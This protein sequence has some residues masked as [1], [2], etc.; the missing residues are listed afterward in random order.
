MKNILWL[1]FI[2][3]LFLNSQTYQEEWKKIET[4]KKQNLPKSALNEVNIIYNKALNEGNDIELLRAIIEKIKYIKQLEEQGD[5]KAILF[6]E[7]ELKKPHQNSTKLILKSILAQMYSRYYSYIYEDYTSKESNI[8]DIDTWSRERLQKKA[9]SLYWE[10]LGEESKYISLD[11]Y[12][13]ILIGGK[14]IKWLQPTLYD[15]L[16]SRALQNFNGDYSFSDSSLFGD[17]STFLLY[18]IYN[19]DK[20]SDKYKSLFIYKSLLK[21]HKENGDANALKSINL[22]RL[23]FINNHFDNKDSDYYIKALKRIKNNNKKAL[24][25]LALIYENRNNYIEALKYAK[26]G[27]ASGDKYVV[28]ISQNIINRITKKIAHIEIEY[29]NLPDENILSKVSYRNMDKLYIK[30]IKLSPKEEDEFLYKNWKEK[31]SYIS[32]LKSIKTFKVDLPKTYDYKR[33]ITEVSLGK[34]NIGSY[35]FVI[36]KDNNFSDSMSYQKINISKIAYVYNGSKI[37]VIDRL[38]GKPLEGVTVKFYKHEYIKSTNK[39]IFLA[40]KETDKNGFVSAKEFKTSFNLELINGEDRVI[41]DNSFYSSHGKKHWEKKSIIFFTDRAIY[42]PSQKI[43]FKG[44]AI[45]KSNYKA[46]KIL[47]NQEVTVSLFNTNNQKVET[48]KFKTDEFGSFYGWFT[49]P[50]SGR[51]GRMHISS[52]K[53]NGSKSF[54]VEEY[55]RA[56]FEVNFEPIKGE[57]SIGDKVTITGEAKAFSGQGVSNA[58]VS[59]KIERV[60]DFPWLSWEDKIPNFYPSIISSGNIKSDKNGKFI[61]KFDTT[62]KDS[63]WLEKYKPVITYKVSVNVTNS[64]GET[65]SESKNI[66]IG[67]VSIDAQMIVDNEIDINSKVNIKL[68]TTNLNGVFQ[69][70]KGRVVVEMIDL[71]KKHFRKRYWT[72]K[73]IDK[74]LYSKQ[75]FE[76]LFKNYRYYTDIKKEKIFIKTLYFDTVT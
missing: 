58:K 56:K 13:D 43:Y 74:P 51:L 72:T 3:T 20:N 38:S 30:V 17:I 15:L 66:T 29:I 1:L 69:P 8:T 64:V 23:K 27:V 59:Y 37:V 54:R 21:L 26:E 52:E 65:Q 6:I 32:T 25:N 41:F 19:L 35:I 16:A 9:D 4:F 49:A 2:L 75:E 44:I 39:Y 42:R 12:K 57:Y 28:P 71:P 61:I 76:K 67:Y 53:I 10:S 24:I 60:V 55:K 48:K 46:P 33:H 11:K 73:D 40:K 34:Y 31:K 63:K 22:K 68:K 62:L 47:P 36:S 7:N 45:T 14:N 50:K 70:L 18:P 5:K